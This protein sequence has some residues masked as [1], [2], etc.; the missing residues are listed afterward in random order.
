VDLGGPHVPSPGLAGFFRNRIPRSKG[1][2]AIVER[3]DGGAWRE[4]AR[5]ANPSDAKL[6]VDEAIAAGSDPGSLRVVAPQMSNL[7]LIVGCLAIAFAVAIVL[8]IVLT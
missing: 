2:A 6:A 5:Y 4:V 3:N 7:V 1:Q 8:V